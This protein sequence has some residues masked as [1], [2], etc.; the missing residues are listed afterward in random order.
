[1]FSIGFD[2]LRPM[3]LDDRKHAAFSHPDWVFEIKHDGYRMLAEFGAGTVRMKTRGGHDCTSW[4][5]EVATS[6]A[7]Y[8]GGPHVVDGEV[9]VLDDIGRSDFNRLQDRA[10]RRCYYP[11][12]DPVVYCM[13][14]TLVH[15][16]D[17]MMREPLFARKARLKQLFTPKPR[18]SLLVVDAI[19]EAGLELYAMAL[20]LKLE[21]LCAK[22]MQSPYLPGERTHLWR[23]LKRPGAIPV[24]RF[25]G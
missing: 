5:P 1:M 20:E 16:G 2:A 23:K 18:Y 10:R 17:N 13:F 3:L 25:K 15:R 7:K 12:C 6:L 11:E 9:C 19:P 4:F 24:E 14:D 22:H 8:K 21:G